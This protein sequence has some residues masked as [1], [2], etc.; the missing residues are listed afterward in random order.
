[1]SNIRQVEVTKRASLSANISQLFI[2]LAMILMGDNAYLN[3]VYSFLSLSLLILAGIILVSDVKLNEKTV[4]YLALAELFSVPALYYYLTHDY[5]FLFFYIPL[6]LGIKFGFKKLSLV[7]LFGI[8]MLFL[9]D[10]TFFGTDEIM[11]GYYSAYLFLHHLNPY[12]PSLTANVYSFY[13]LTK[14]IYRLGTPYT[15]GGVVTNLNYPSL[16]FLIQIPAV[17]LKIS[18]N[19]TILLFYLLTGVLMYFYTNELTFLLF[20]SAYLL[21][22]NYL[23][24]P[25]GGVDD[26]IWVFFALM[27]MVVKDVRLKGI[28][29]GLSISYKQD[30]LALLPF[31]L[32]QLKKDRLKFL[33]YSLVTFLIINSYFI[34]LS[35]LTYF[36]DVM[37]PIKSSMLQ[38]GYGIDLLSFTDLYYLYPLFFLL[39]PIIIVIA[40]LI[41]GRKKWNGVIYFAFLFFYRV[42]WNYL[43]YWPFFSYVQKEEEGKVDKKKKTVVITLTVLSLLVLGLVFHFAYLSYSN[44]IHMKVLKVFEKDD[45]IYGFLLNVTYLGK[46]EIKPLFR[47]LTSEAMISGNGLLWKSNATILKSGESEIVYIYAPCNYLYVKIVKNEVVEINAYYSDYQGFVKLTLQ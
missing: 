27:S 28:F 39:S 47:I 2:F 24:Y 22:Y 3:Y 32:F 6:V 46:G 30:P 42:L 19:Y 35:P 20:I 8:P 4:K 12:E 10:K 25:L 33:L 11:I 26:I 15:T 13:H 18:P 17:L 31:Y 29:Y 16:F 5:L 40:G 1:M 7:L 23:Y 14:Y 45:Y 37:A 34:I 21:N 44:A 41:I 9:P 36:E 43:M 38:I